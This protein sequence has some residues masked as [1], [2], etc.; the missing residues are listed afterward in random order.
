M[1]WLL[2]VRVEVHARLVRATTALHVALVADPFVFVLYVK[3]HRVF[4]RRRVSATSEIMQRSTY[5]R[6]EATH[7]TSCVGFY[8]RKD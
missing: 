3:L 5:N 7:H 6:T 2:P 1:S 4:P 8:V